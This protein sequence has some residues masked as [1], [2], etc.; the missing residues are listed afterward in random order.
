MSRLQK[1]KP[2]APGSFQESLQCCLITGFD[3]FGKLA[4]N[5]SG[6][7]VSMLPDKLSSL[8]NES[9]K[10]KSIVFPTCC[11]SWSI[12]KRT[13]DR[14]SSKRTVLVLTG[15]A[16]E[17]TQISFERFALNIRHYRIKDKGGHKRQDESIDARGPDAL[18]TSVPLVPLQRHMKRKG[19]LCEISNHAGTFICNEIYYRALRYQQ[20]HGYPQT[21]LFVHLPMP[22]N[23]ARALRTKGNAKSKE[24]LACLTSDKSNPIKL[25]LSAVIET[26]IFCC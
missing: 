20:M 8:A 5:P 26:A 3:G 22:S 19:Y 18:R 7:V 11:A 2:A 4:S 25:M 12:L 10:V 23:Y 13:L 16:E 14:L 6:T 24:L 17:R 21:V 15:V 1:T 9:V